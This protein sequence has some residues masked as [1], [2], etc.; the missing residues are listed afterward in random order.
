MPKGL[1]STVIRKH[2]PRKRP[3]ASSG[4]A[5]NHLHLPEKQE[6]NAVCG[7]TVLCTTCQSYLA[8]WVRL[9]S[10]PTSCFWKD[11]QCSD[12]DAT[13][14]HLPAKG[15]TSLSGNIPVLDLLELPQFSKLHVTAHGLITCHGQRVHTL[16]LVAA[17]R[18]VWIYRLGHGLGL[19]NVVWDRLDKVPPD[20]R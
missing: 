11:L 13:W 18:R 9:Q 2:G 17:G 3:Q 8:M 19:C 7:G 20:C 5:T 6:S 4:N 15:R 10:L 1:A 14:L 12:N 16:T